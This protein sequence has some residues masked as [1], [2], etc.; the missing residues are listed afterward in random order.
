MFEGLIGLIGVGIGAIITY[1]FT[2]KNARK[3]M[4]YH[5]FFEQYKEFMQLKEKLDD[6]LV[7]IEIYQIRDVLNDKIKD[8]EF[9]IKQLDKTLDIMQMA[10][11]N[12]SRIKKHLLNNQ[13]LL[14]NNH[15]YIEEI[16]KLRGWQYKQIIFEEINKYV[17]NIGKLN[18]TLL[19]ENEE[20]YLN[21]LNEFSEKL[22]RLKKQ[23]E[24][25]LLKERIG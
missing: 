11:K 6:N 20:K 21:F 5:I 19:L 17:I 25:I 24:Q 3:S 2:N 7:D 9:I 23:M 16:I 8:K 18:K 12:I 15:I 22:I 13:Y 1:Y 14:E 10:Y 4:V